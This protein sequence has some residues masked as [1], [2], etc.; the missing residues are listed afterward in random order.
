RTPSS[1]VASAQRPSSQ[2]NDRQSAC[3]LHRR[4]VAQGPQLPPQPMSVA[5]WCRLS[6]SPLSTW[7]V[8]RWQKLLSQSEF[9]LH[10]WP[11]AQRP[12]E[13]PPQSTSVSVLFCAP[14]SQV[15]KVQA[16]SSQIP[17]PQSL[18]AWQAWRGG[19]GAQE[20][21]QST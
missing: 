19:Q 20:P 1:Q 6:T 5:S 7:Q 21:P 3:T 13:G 8:P 16:P 12:Q 2:T 11:G 9:S 4:L 17:L 18:A 14:S 15:G 10:F